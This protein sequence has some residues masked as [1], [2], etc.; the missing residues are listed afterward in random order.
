MKTFIGLIGLVIGLFVCG[1]DGPPAALAQAPAVAVTG[2]PPAAAPPAGAPP[3]VV[4][5]P[6]AANPVAKSPDLEKIGAVLLIFL[7]LSVVF[8]SAL[9]PIFTWSVFLKYFEGKGFKIP[10]TVLLALLVFWKYELDII[11]D[12][13]VALDY[14]QGGRTATGELKPPLSFWG[15]VLTALLIAGGSDGVFRI[16]ARLGIRNPT[17]TQQRAQTLQAAVPGKIALTIA[18]A[19]ANTQSSYSLDG[20]A[21]VP[22]AGTTKEIAD[23]APGDH[24]LVIQATKGGL[25]QT[26]R[27]ALK[28]ESGATM[29]VLIAV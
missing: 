8:E 16:F 14:Y 22:F 12:V 6:D 9:T 13:L 3:A 26:V 7:V 1:W 10:I 29:Q 23:V 4:E 18:G 24:L 11:R 27:Q 5:R 25:P 2:A 19:D 21:A 15:Q 20:A 17:Q 28:I